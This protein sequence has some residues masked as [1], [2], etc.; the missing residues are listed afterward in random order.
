MSL[1]VSKMS[2]EDL[3]RRGVEDVIRLLR[4]VDAERMQR[5]MEHKNL[6]SDVNRRMQVC[7]EML[8]VNKAANL[9]AGIVYNTVRIYW[10]S[11]VAG[12]L[13]CYRCTCWRSGG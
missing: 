7:E 13:I 9:N 1:S 5:M 12:T 3:R 10:P 8:Q 6:M 2:D 11:S 4:K